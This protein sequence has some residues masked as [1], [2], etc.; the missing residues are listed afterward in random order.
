MGAEELVNP[1]QRRETLAELDRPY[2][3]SAE[4]AGA[5]VK[6]LFPAQFGKMTHEEVMGWPERR[7]R[8]WL[9]PRLLILT[10]LALLTIGLL[11]YL[12]RM[13]ITLSVVGLLLDIVG[14]YWL[15]EGL[16]LSDTEANY[17]GS[18]DSLSR[19]A[20]MKRLE[21][22]QVKFGVA[23]AFTGFASQLLGLALPILNSKW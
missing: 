15:A 21:S 12:G 3:D 7:F 8:I 23:V 22:R 16:M 4:L 19:W 10:G 20:L 17:W 13:S 14:V 5:P 18:W 9:R 2:E 6:K 1:E 11:I